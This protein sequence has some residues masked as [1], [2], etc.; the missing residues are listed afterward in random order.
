MV[1][2]SPTDT[3]QVGIGAPALALGLDATTK[4]G[5]RLRNR[6]TGVEMPSDFSMFKL[7]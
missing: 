3:E 7:R 4:L 1:V 6:R 2:V 5:R